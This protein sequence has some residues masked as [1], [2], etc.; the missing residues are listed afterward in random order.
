MSQVY[1]IA[2][3][4]IAHRNICKYRPQFSTP[5]EHD[6]HI[7]SNWNKVV[8]KKDDIIWVLGDFL[9]HNDKYDM[10][11]IVKRLKGIIRVITGNHC[12]IPYYYDLNIPMANGLLKKYGYWISHAPIHPLELRGHKN[13]HGHIHYKMIEDNRCINNILD[14]RYINVCC[15]HVNYTPISLDEIRSRS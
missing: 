1:F 5:Q 13:V 12:H 14:S 11:S 9:I 2:D 10:A 4:H 6:E 7:I 15:E 3:L 8:K